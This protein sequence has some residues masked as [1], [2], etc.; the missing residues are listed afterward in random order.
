MAGL[1]HLYED[2]EKTSQPVDQ[3]RFRQGGWHLLAAGQRQLWQ[4]MIGLCRE[5]K[6]GLAG[7]DAVCCKPGNNR[8][9][10]LILIFLMTLLWPFCPLLLNY[11]CHQFLIISY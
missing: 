1:R 3:G 9:I 2:V 11:V 8:K 6:R 7:R 4:P 5:R 10:I